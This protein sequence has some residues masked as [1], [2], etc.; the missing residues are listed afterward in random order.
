RD[1]ASRARLRAAVSI[2]LLLVVVPDATLLHATTLHGVH[3]LVQA[4]VGQAA[5]PDAQKTREEY[6]KAAAAGNAKAM[7]NLGYLYDRGQDY[8]KAKEWYEK[9]AARGSATAM[10]NLAFLYYQGHGVP[11]DYQKAR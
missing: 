10:N 5:A 6:E 3:A 8:Q 2:C 11:Q 1:V 4:V 7:A 9:A